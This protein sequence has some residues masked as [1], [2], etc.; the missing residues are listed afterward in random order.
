MALG[1]DGAALEWTARILREADGFLAT[2]SVADARS[3][4]PWPP[5]ALARELPDDVR[6]TV[7][8]LLGDGFGRRDKLRIAVDLLGRCRR[9][10]GGVPRLAGAAASGIRLGLRES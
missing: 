4:A 8:L 10:R 3:P 7:A 6:A 1:P 9:G 2:G 5:E